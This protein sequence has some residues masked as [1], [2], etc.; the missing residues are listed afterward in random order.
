MYMVNT[1]LIVRFFLVDNYGSVIFAI[2]NIFEME[3]FLNSV[4]LSLHQRNW[5]G[6]LAL[7]LAMPDICG[8][9]ETPALASGRRYAEWF[10]QYVG[11]P[12]YVVPEGPVK[13]YLGL[14]EFI[15]GN[16]C[17]ALRCAYLHEGT[18]EITD[19]RARE[20]INSYMFT[21][22]TGTHTN[23]FVKIP[24]ELIPVIEDVIPIPREYFIMQL[25][26]SVFCSDIVSGVRTWLAA[27]DT[28]PVKM[29]KVNTRIQ[30]C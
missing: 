1:Q 29:E 24:E 5:H 15:T 30:I 21:S 10:K 16:D 7:S 14:D 18:S 6:A 19:Q 4:E 8:K 11:D 9:I 12:H 26:I 2:L 25:E 3:H 28:D 27:I 22:K 23:A 20:V 13:A 17:Y